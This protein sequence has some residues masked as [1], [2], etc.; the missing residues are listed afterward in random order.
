[1]ELKKIKDLLIYKFGYSQKEI[2]NLSEEEILKIWNQKQEEELIIAKNPNKF[3]YIKS[4][5]VPKNVE[6][7]T[8]SKAGVIVF[9]V[10]ILMLIAVFVLFLVL[11]FK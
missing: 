6:T 7:K 2:E 9:I 4:M 5:P 1:M 8:S 3:F 11:A 10:F